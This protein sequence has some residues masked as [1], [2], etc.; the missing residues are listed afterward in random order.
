MKGKVLNKRKKKKKDT[1]ETCIRV[2]ILTP[3]KQIQRNLITFF[4][5]E[6]TS[7]RVYWLSYI[8]SPLLTRFEKGLTAT[9]KSGVSSRATFDPPLL[10]GLSEGHVDTDCI[11]CFS[12][13]VG[14]T[15]LSRQYLSSHLQVEKQVAM[16]RQ[17]KRK[18]SGSNNIHKPGSSRNGKACNPEL[19]QHIL[20]C[21]PV[22]EH[23][24]LKY[25]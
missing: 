24:G 23:T 21:K 8:F 13:K 1:Q 5:L 22:H 20:P 10:Q 3:G 2:Y 17:A 18:C 11:P 25:K 16:Q 7:I 19:R 4:H 15:L 12:R 6:K 9:Y 14:N